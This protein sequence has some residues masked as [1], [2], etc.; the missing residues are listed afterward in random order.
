MSTV[1]TTNSPAYISGYVVKEAAKGFFNSR[2][3]SGFVNSEYRNDFEERGAKKGDTIFVRRPAMFKVR[4]G[5]GMEIQDVHEDKIPVTLPE[6]KGVDFQFS[7]RELTL[8]IDKGGNEYSKRWIRPAGS[9]LAEDDDAEGLEIAANTAGSVVIV[10]YGTSNSGLYEKF[11]DAKGL[12]NKFLAPKDPTTR[13]AFVGSDIENKLTESVKQLYN[14]ARSIDKAIKDGTI[15]DVAGLTWGSTDLVHLRTCGAGGD[16]LVVGS[17]T[18]D[19]DNFTQWIPVYS[20]SHT[21]AV[22]DT[23]EF[24][25]SYFINLKTKKVYQNK[26]Q[27]KVLAT[28]GTGSSL[29]CLVYSIRPIIDMS[30]AG[31]QNEAG[32][33]KYAMANCS[34]LPASGSTAVCLGVAGEDYLCCPV[35]HKNAITQTHVD[36]ARPKKVEM[37]N[38]VNYK[39]VVIRFIEDY[40]VTTDQFPDRLDMLGV[41]TAVL[42]EW[43]VDVEIQVTETT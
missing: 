4:K 11:L 30:S 38:T 21:L 39:D 26:L 17:I 9:T 3:F 2:L 18:P 7:A 16:T 28:R 37:C 33:K 1:T 13:M 23:I 10:S 32:R 15:Q 43:C 35:L 25:A 6:Q 36:L 42:P 22:G 8:D 27:R 41:Y 19:Y 31:N 34:A 24:N 5:A 40:S 20:A 12:L 29:E 14:N